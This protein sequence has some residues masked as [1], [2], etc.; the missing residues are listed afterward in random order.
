MKVKRPPNKRPF[1]I[2]MFGMKTRSKNNPAEEERTS[3]FSE[4]YQLH[5]DVE[6]LAHELRERRKRKWVPLRDHVEALQEISIRLKVLDTRPKT[7]FPDLHFTRT[8][9]FWPS[10]YR[11]LAKS[12]ITVFCGLES[13]V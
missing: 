9:F 12:V 13:V 8:K 3:P 10:K 5:S 4:L 1:C 6:D 2:S 11:W 7:K